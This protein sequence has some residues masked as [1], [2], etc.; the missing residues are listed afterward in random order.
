MTLVWAQPDHSN[1]ASIPAT[2]VS[3]AISPAN[4]QMPIPDFLAGSQE[5]AYLLLI[6]IAK[7]SP[8]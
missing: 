1:P 7:L 4:P 6:S 2:P 8:V 3:M 5:Q